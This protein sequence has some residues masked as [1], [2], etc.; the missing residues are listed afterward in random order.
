VRPELFHRDIE[1]KP[2]FLRDLAS[3]IDAGDAFPW[4]TI[5]RHGRLLLAGM[6]SSWFAAQ[7]AAL[8]L[9]RAG[10][11][12]VAELASSEA[13]W[14]VTDDLTVVAIS[15][16]GGS[17]ETLDLLDTLHGAPRL[18]A[19]TNTAASP[20]RERAT[21]TV[22]LLAGEEVSGVACR[23]ALHTVLALL[24]L[25]E[26][27]T[28]HDLRLA[29]ACRDAAAAVDHLLD[30]RDAW[31]GGVTDALA[32]PHGSWLLA[33]ADRIT[34]ALQ[35][36]LMIREVPRR[37]ADG[38][39]TGVWSHVDVYLTKTL[40]YR[41]LVFPG[42]RYDAEAA[43]WM[44]ERGSTVVSVHPAGETGFSSAAAAVTYP[45]TGHPLLPLLVETTVP[46]LVAAAWFG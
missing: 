35:G 32:G 37:Q 44:T 5:A 7:V 21:H 33:P 23:S 18:V 30:R 4:P 14:P 11:N 22:E 39:E 34:S 36:A 28:G 25:E 40:D 20:L 24:S 17:I 43:R 16:S 15:A 19:L 8:R 46:E 12:A 26:R 45:P 42:S 31:V 27:L 13:V 1:S 9:R 3:A 29:A 38:C 2:A 10:V 41:A 6:G